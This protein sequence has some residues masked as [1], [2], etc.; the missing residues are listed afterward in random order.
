M[1][2]Q[3]TIRTFNKATLWVAF[4]FL[5]FL[6]VT[7]SEAWAQDQANIEVAILEKASRVYLA[8]A[9][10][11]ERPLSFEKKSFG[12]EEKIFAVAELSNFPK[13]KHEFS[14][15]WTD[16]ANTL[17]EHTRYPFHITAV[18]TRLWSWLS[19][20]RGT[21][22][23]MLQW[24]DPAAG[25]EDFIGPWEVEVHIDG[26]KLATLEMEVNC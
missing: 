1:L 15:K 24:L 17:R 23:G 6:G 2:K 13:G 8:L 14:V 12:C 25:L 22:S 20:R 10:E 19:L 11:N 5:V 4:V 3:A 21:G 18:E 16:P 7:N 26:K 9:D